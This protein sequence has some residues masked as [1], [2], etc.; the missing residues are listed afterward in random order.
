V[1]LSG[2]INYCESILHLYAF[3]ICIR[4]S[5]PA[6]LQALSEAISRESDPPALDN[7][8]GAVARLICTNHEA[9]PLGQVLPVFLN[10][11]PLKE[12]FEENDM[13]QKAFRVLYMNDL[14]SIEPHL[15]QMLII[16]I[17]SVYNKQVASE[18]ASESAMNF[19]KEIRT[20]YPDTFNK[21]AN[22]NP[23]VFNY[24]Q[25]L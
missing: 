22:T 9:V 2:G 4:R 18:E 11:L 5:Y 8:C 17:D 12:D 14:P 13:V 16:T 20:H 6:I 24:V 7:I 3:F 15:E 23:E 10:H 25:A 19:M 1:P 21:V